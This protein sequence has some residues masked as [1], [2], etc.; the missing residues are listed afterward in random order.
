MGLVIAI[1]T[2]GH[3]APPL[4]QDARMN[5]VDPL[6][7]G[8]HG[9]PEQSALARVADTR[10]AELAMAGGNSYTPPIAASVPVIGS[11]PGAQQAGQRAD[12][13]PQPHFVTRSAAVPLRRLTQL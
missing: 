6:P 7:G 4:S 12:P 5:S 3:Q 13:P 10:H 2:G 9:T 8:L 1:V 11:P